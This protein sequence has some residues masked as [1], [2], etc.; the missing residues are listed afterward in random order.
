[1][2]TPLYPQVDRTVVRKAIETWCTAVHANVAWKVAGHDEEHDGEAQSSVQ[3][4]SVLEELV[5]TRPFKTAGD[6]DHVTF[7]G[8]IAILVDEEST[9][10]TVYAVEIATQQMVDAVRDRISTADGHVIEVTQTEDRVTYGGNED[11]TRL[12]VG[13]VSFAGQARRASGTSTG[14]LP[15]PEPEP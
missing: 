6:P 10:D 12:A 13:L 1:M 9:E 4:T 15:A 7:T 5:L 8:S 11:G 2:A 14:V 3:P